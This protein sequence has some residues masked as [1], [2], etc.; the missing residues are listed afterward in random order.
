MANAACSDNFSYLCPTLLQHSIMFF[1]FLRI[2]FKSA[3]PSRGISPLKT[4][5]YQAKIKG[6][7]IA[8]GDNQIFSRIQALLAYLSIYSTLVHN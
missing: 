6:N 7:K 8:Q 5:D 1:E 3:P 2:F 4:L